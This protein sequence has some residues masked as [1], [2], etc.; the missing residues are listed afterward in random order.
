V[1]H[2]SADWVQTLEQM[3]IFEG[4]ASTDRQ[5]AAETCLQT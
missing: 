2:P 1:A 4:G 3:G 5:T